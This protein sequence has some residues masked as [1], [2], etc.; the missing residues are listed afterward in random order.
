[1]IQESYYS[2]RDGEYDLKETINGKEYNTMCYNVYT[3]EYVYDEQ[4]RRI[5]M[6]YRSALVYE[7]DQ[8]E[9]VD[10]YE[11]WEVFHYSYDYDEQGRLVKITKV[12]ETPG[13]AYLTCH[14]G[15]PVTLDPYISTPEICT[16]VYTY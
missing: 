5:Q 6:T 11:S 10:K 1:M 14:L 13:S 7:S 3:K 9:I 12:S 2:G 8:G 15:D 4:N 16:V